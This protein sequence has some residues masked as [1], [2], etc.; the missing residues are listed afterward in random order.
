MSSVSI[1]STTT[2]GNKKDGKNK[3]DRRSI[4]QRKGRAFRKDTDNNATSFANNH[5]TTL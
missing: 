4:Q 1:T 5:A 2:C 3:E